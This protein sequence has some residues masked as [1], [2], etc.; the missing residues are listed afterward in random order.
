MIVKIQGLS[1]MLFIADFEY[2]NKSDVLIKSVA[3]NPKLFSQRLFEN[4]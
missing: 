3:S 4:V 1:Q 2:K